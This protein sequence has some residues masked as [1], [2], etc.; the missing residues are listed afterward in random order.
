MIMENYDEI[1]KIYRYLISRDPEMRQLGVI[2]CNNDF[3]R[4]YFPTELLYPDTLS[5]QYAARARIRVLIKRN[6][7]RCKRENNKIPSE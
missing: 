1:I 5:S 2:L 6:E 4:K 7:R 3:I